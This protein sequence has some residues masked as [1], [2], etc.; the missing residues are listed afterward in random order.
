MALRLFGMFSGNTRTS[1]CSD[2][3]QHPL[4]DTRACRSCAQFYPQPV[5]SWS[6]CIISN[7]VI[8]K[9]SAP[10]TAADASHASVGIQRVNT[11]VCGVGTRYHAQI[12]TDGKGV[13]RTASACGF[14]GVPQF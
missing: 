3:F 5:G 11:N 6:S 9:S 10:A 2:T 14:P 13:N 12:C 1:N 7:D 8:T 4:I